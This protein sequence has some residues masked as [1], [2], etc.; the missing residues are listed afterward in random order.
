[1]A[2]SGHTRGH[3]RLRVGYHFR[4]GRRRASGRLLTPSRAPSRRR[5]SAKALF[6]WDGAALDCV[7]RRR[8]SRV[9]VLSLQTESRRRVV[10]GVLSRE[11]DWIGGGGDFIVVVVVVVSI[12]LARPPLVAAERTFGGRGWFLSSLGPRARLDTAGRQA[13]RTVS[14]FSLNRKK[15]EREERNRYG[16]LSTTVILKRIKERFF[17][18]GF[19]LLNKTLTDLRSDEITR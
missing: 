19:R 7:G 10:V 2:A 13:S 15:I 4:R 3:A 11:E 8:R 16:P 12:F 14:F 18:I 6:F 17:P 9:V 1:M 5:E